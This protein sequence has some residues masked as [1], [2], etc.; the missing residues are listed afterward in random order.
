MLTSNFATGA[1]LGDNDKRVDVMPRFM[2]DNREQNMKV[3]GQFKTLADKK[4]C[5]MPQLA[6]AWLMKQG[7]DIIP[8]PGTKKM[9]YLEENWASIKVRLTDED[10]AEIRH[11]VENAEI[12][13]PTL[14]PQF[15]S[16]N[17]ADTAAEE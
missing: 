1:T 12:A 3:V 11:F 4:N 13:G 5:T 14:P 9:K 17:Y 2:G 10:E 6:L 15:S 7:S 16:Y 8:I